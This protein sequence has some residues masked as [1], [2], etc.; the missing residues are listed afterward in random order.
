[1]LVQ[2]ADRGSGTMIRPSG[3]GG[4]EAG[5]AQQAG[6]AGRCPVSRSCVGCPPVWPWVGLRSGQRRTRGNA[7]DKG[8]TTGGAHGKRTFG[9]TENPK[10]LGAFTG[11]TDERKGEVCACGPNRG[12]GN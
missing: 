3:T 9:V 1:M 2:S 4:A 7:A 6:A 8:G 10:F 5:V 11:E 12:S